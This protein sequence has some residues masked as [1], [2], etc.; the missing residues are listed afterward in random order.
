MGVGVD[1]GANFLVQLSGPTSSHILIAEN[2]NPNHR[3]SVP[4]R[5]GSYRIV[6]VQGLEGEISDSAS[7]QEIL[8]EANPPRFARDGRP[9]PA[10]N[11]S[12]SPLPFGTA[13]PQSPEFSSHAL[14]YANPQQEMIELRL[15][16]GLLL[17]MDPSNREAFGGTDK[18]LFTSVP[19]TWTPKPRTTEGI[20]VAAFALRVVPSPEQGPK[21]V[22]SSLPPLRNGKLAGSTAVYTWQK[23]NQVRYRPYFKQSYYALSKTFAELVKKF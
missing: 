9:F 12:R 5:P 22:S 15:P 4:G 8:F 10:L 23:W 2:Y 17:M 16:W 18:E 20:S 3:F 1:W 21:V 11:Y 6:R 14:W 13:D 19:G 7:F